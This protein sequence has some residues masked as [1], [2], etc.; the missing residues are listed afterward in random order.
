MTD[1]SA[2]D[3]VEQHEVYARIGRY[4]RMARE[5]AGLSSL[6]LARMLRID[7]ST[8][9]K[10]ERGERRPPVITLYEASRKLRTRMDYLFYGDLSGVDHALRLRL[11]KIYRQELRP[12]QSRELA[13]ILDDEMSKFGI[14]PNPQPIRTTVPRGRRGDSPRADTRRP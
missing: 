2:Q 4:L 8:L 13:T 14:D 1:R 9:S 6:E 3:E 5:A 12:L 7:G 10:V 11:W